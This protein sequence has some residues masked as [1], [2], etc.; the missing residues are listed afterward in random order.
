MPNEKVTELQQVFPNTP[1]LPSLIP[2]DAGLN[3]HV[4]NITQI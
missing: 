2:Q 4:Y 3:S 1:V